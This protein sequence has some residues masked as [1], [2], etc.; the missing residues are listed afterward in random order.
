M[1]EQEPCWI[2]CATFSS[3]LRWCLAILKLLLASH[4]TAVLEYHSVVTL[5][6]SIC[7]SIASRRFFFLIGTLYLYR[8]VTMYITT[9]PVPGMHMTC[10]PKV[11]SMQT[12]EQHISCC[13]A[14]HS[15]APSG[16]HFACKRATKKKLFLL[17]FF[18]GH[19]QYWGQMSGR[20]QGLE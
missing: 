15:W 1:S 13:S 16:T 14:L 8:C 12:S 20:D 9:L 10:A 2:I 18:S 5:I 7:R 3:I 17:P 4:E 19:L 11:S 6:L